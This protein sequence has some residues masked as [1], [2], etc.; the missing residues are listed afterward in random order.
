M[1]N[2]PIKF[3]SRDKNFISRQNQILKKLASITS[4]VYPS[5]FI[6]PFFANKN[7]PLR[8]SAVKNEKRVKLAKFA[9]SQ[10][11]SGTINGWKCYRNFYGTGGRFGVCPNT[12]FK[13]TDGWT[14]SFTYCLFSVR[15]FP[16]RKN[17]KI[18]LGQIFWM[19]I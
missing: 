12:H 17:W 5:K 3:R 6:F 8:I 7:L 18:N 1:C 16:T 14:T 9:K 19:V 15:N 10:Y 2:W 4:K 11:W 13:H